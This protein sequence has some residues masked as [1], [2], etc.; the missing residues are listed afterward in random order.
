MGSIADIYRNITLCHDLDMFSF[1]N[2]NNNEQ[3]TPT[4]VYLDHASATPLRPEVLSAM[5][6]YFIESFGNPGS[7]HTEGQQAKAALEDARTSVAR[8]L[9]VQTECVT[10]TSGGTES[11]NLA[12]MGVVRAQHDNGVPYEQIEI[13]TTAIE[14]PATSKTFEY[15]ATLGVVV[16]TVPIDEGGQ[17]ILSQLHSLLTPATLLV[18]LAYVNSE[19]GVIQD[20]GAISRVLNKFSKA[21]ESTTYLHVD[22]AQAPLWLPCEL[23]RLGCDLMSLDAG[24]FGGPKGVGALIHL[25]RVP[26]KNISYGGGQE[27]GLRPGTESVAS[28]VGFATAFLLAQSNWAKNTETVK[29]LQEYFFEQLKEKIPTAKINGVLGEYRVANN[30][31]ISILGIDS[32]FAVVSL[33]VAGISI[34]TKSACSSAGGGGSSV[35]QAITGDIGRSNTTLRFSLGPTTTRAEVERAIDQLRKH[36]VTLEN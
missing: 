15:L 14:H 32:E 23:S 13:I 31:N 9:S 4:R 8:L 27:R 29:V 25:K 36:I 12:T 28:V 18:S 35:V 10:F 17:I 21:H 2:K 16:K 1:F 22:A 7:I 19:I 30:I 5:M 20:V 6:P 24:K 34:S 26:L 3:A 11:N 33:D